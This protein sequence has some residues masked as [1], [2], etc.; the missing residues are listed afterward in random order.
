MQESGQP[1]I[2]GLAGS[3]V[4]GV[5]RV[6]ENVIA[7]KRALGHSYAFQQLGEDDAEDARFLHEEKSD[8]RDGGGEDLQQFV[9]YPF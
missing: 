5:K 4:A 3:R 8:G 6:P 9:P 2:E 1:Q 7:V